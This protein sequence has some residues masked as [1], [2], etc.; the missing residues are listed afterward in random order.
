[1][2]ALSPVPQI[3]LLTAG[4]LLATGCLVWAVWRIGSILGSPIGR[5]AFRSLHSEEA[6][7]F[8]GSKLGGWLGI[9]LSYG[10]F[11]WG[12]DHTTGLPPVALANGQYHL[13]ALWI[14]KVAA[15]AASGSFGVLA[16][17]SG[18]VKIFGLDARVEGT[19]DVDEKEYARM[20]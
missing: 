8:I 15:K 13:I 14:L 4:T 7:H 10:L 16:L 12:L 2:D 1:M 3:V 20:A 18:V 6:Q 19:V 17:L 5:F 9:F 11:H